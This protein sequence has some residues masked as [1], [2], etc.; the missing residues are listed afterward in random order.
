MKK[1]FVLV[2]VMVLGWGI[3]ATAQLKGSWCTNVAINPQTPAV[4]SFS[5]TLIVD[6]DVGGWVFGSKSSLTLSGWS[7]Q[8][9]TAGGLLGGLRVGSDLVFNPATAS[10]TRWT[11]NG[12]LA[13][14][15]LTITS[16]FLQGPAGS[17]W[18]FG[19]AG[20][21]G[22]LTADASVFLNMDASGALVRQT[23]SCL[24]WDGMRIHLCFPFCCIEQVCS[25]VN[26][27]AS[28]FTGVQFC[29]AG[30]PV[31]SIE[32]L[33]LSACVDF[34]VGPDEGK[35]VSLT[36][37]LK[38]PAGCFTLYT[39]IISAPGAGSLSITGLSIYGFGLSCTLGGVVFTDATS[40]S[41]SKN[42]AV[43]GDAAY[44]EKMRFFSA[45]DSCC[46]GALNFDVAVWF[47]QTSSQLFDFGKISTT[48]SYG[49]GENLTVT[50]GT[51]ITT[52]G[53]VEWDIGFCLY[54]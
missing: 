25:T 30:I 26:F 16:L 21:A 22:D 8:Q 43:T 41:P 39:S 27:D 10:F 11:V 50:G 48:L 31:P 36:P 47:S 51:M 18:T 24:C 6:F 54:W 23:D 9:F 49:F 1:S 40:L 7:T 17:G 4:T 46:G 13:L 38:M 20:A 12:S 28:G 53:V 19:G 33:L 3:A 34:V 42:S 44:W 15:G 29:V 5:S 35:S 37:S 32:W 2:L 14:G 52:L 45:T